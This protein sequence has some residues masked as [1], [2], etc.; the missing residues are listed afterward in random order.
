MHQKKVEDRLN[1]IEH[2]VRELKLFESQRG[3]LTILRNTEG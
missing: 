1:S 3:F 2:A